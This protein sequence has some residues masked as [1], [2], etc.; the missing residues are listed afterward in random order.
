MLKFD[1]PFFILRKASLQD[2][3]ALQHKKKFLPFTYSLEMPIKHIRAWGGRRIN[4]ID[5]PFTAALNGLNFDQSLKFYKEKINS[6]RSHYGLIL[7]NFDNN[8]FCNEIYPWDKT[9]DPN[10]KFKQLSLT[11]KKE[12]KININTIND[13]D[14][15]IIIKT[16]I[17]R[18]L[19]LYQNLKKIGYCEK[20]ANDT[21]LRANFLKKGDK[22][23]ALIRHGEHRIAC[24]PK[25]GQ[26][27]VRLWIRSYDIIDIDMK[28]NKQN[29]LFN[30]IYDGNLNNSPLVNCYGFFFV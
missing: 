18:L 4:D 9:L 2:L 12:L 13:L 5:N 26:H 6:I 30:R 21:P 24:L 23:L 14:N 28:N 7:N 17:Q 11:L 22:F 3:L 29:F 25:I 16:E 8:F 15:R 27:K 1:S 10:K 20:I 19:L